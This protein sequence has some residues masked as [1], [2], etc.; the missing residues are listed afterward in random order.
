MEI[1]PAGADPTQLVTGQADGYFGFSTDQGVALEDKGLSVVYASA[2]DLGFGGYA[3]VLFATKDR[4]AKDKDK[5]T[6]FLRGTIMG[7]EWSNANPDKAAEL[8]VNKYG[9]KGQDLELQ[10]KVAAKQVEL[11]E[12]DKGVM[13]MDLAQMQQIIDDQVAIQSIETAVKAE[14]VMTTSIL[15][16]A[17][18][19]KTSLLGA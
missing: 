16:A 6:K 10:K 11:I 15:E 19:G 2:T 5:L 9:P 1:I 4:I 14:D 12:S 18:D 17:Y 3:D 13:W 8:V 7:Y